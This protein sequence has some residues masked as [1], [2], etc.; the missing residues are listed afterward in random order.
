VGPLLN[1]TFSIDQTNWVTKLFDVG[2]RGYTW[3][4]GDGVGDQGCNWGAQITVTLCPRGGVPY[5]PDQRWAAV[6]GK[7][8]ATDEGPHASLFDC[9][10]SLPR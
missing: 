1:G 3:A 6:G 7:C 5:R 9:Q 8:L 10:N 2:Y 4:Y